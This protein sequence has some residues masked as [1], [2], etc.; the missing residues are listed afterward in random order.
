M[1][2]KKDRDIKKE[3][4]HYNRQNVLDKESEKNFE[5]EERSLIASAIPEKS[6]AK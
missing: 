5:K 2:K 6:G 3:G 1:S 4:G